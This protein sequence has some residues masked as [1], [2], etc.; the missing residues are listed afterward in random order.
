[1]KKIIIAILFLALNTAARAQSLTADDIINTAFNRENGDDSYFQVEMLLVDRGN[2]ERKRA[3]EIFT[4]DNGQF[5]KSLIKFTLPADI[6][7]TSFLSEEISPGQDSQYLYLPELGRARRIVSSQ[8]ALR[9]VNTDFT[10]E[11]MRRRWPKQDRHTLLNEEA[12]AGRGCFVVESIPLD[13]SQY[14]KR[15][16]W[17]DKESFVFLTIQFYDRKGE[18]CKIFNA[19][20]LTLKDGIWTAMQSQ[21]EDLKEKHKTIMKIIALKYN[22]GL[23]EEMFTVQNVEAQ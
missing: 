3:L 14:S 15:V 1:M 4:K 17:I 7:G 21:M 16:S 9:F 19:E 13:N 11:D 8:K 18:L 12:V 5:I 20:G 6:A 10:Y 2:S 23:S 22:Q